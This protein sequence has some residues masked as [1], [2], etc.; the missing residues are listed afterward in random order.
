MAQD[1]PYAKYRQGPQPVTIG[2]PD[3]YRPREEERKDVATQLDEERVRIARENLA[4]EQSGQT[5]QQGNAKFD[6]VATLRKEFNALPQ[7]REY[8]SVMPLLM[9]GLQTAPNPQG[10]NALIYAYAKIMD[11]GSVVRESEGESAANTA[12]FFAAQAEKIKKNLGWS[13]ARGLPAGAAQGLRD[14]MNR[15]VAQM[16]KTYG[17]ER[18]RYQE[19][20]KRQNFDPNDVVGQ[21]PAAPFIDKYLQLVP[22]ANQSRENSAI[23]AFNQGA[24]TLDPKAPFSTDQDKEV[25]AVVNAAFKGG[26]TFE[27][28]DAMH[29]A[30]TKNPAAPDGVPLTEQHRQYVQARDRGLPVSEFP[31]AT[32][33]QPTAMQD[34]ITNAAKNPWG[35]ALFGGV[36]ADLAGIP[37]RLAGLD[38]MDAM[39]AENPKATFAGEMAGNIG[40]TL[41]TGG[42]LKALSGVARL[43]PEVT[44]MLANPLTADALYGGI[45]GGMS[46]DNPTLGAMGGV[47]AALI[48]GSLSNKITG[49]LAKRAAVKNA[50]AAVPSVDDLKSQAKSLYDA[51]DNSGA[52]LDP[53]QTANLASDVRAFLSKEGVIS[54]KGSLSEVHPKV[55]EALR[56]VDEYAGQTMDPAQMQTVRKVAANAAQS[57]DASEARVGK[58]V[59]DIVDSHI[60]PVVPDLARAR[61]ISSRYLQG[62]ELEQARQLAGARAGQFSGSGFENALR[63]EYR[64]LD[65]GIVKGQN[66]FD[67]AVVEAIMNVG[68]GT[69]ASNFA[70]GVGKLAPTGVVSSG[71]SAGVPFGIGTAVGGPA[72]GSALSAGSLTTGAIGRKIATAMTDRNAQIAEILARN[73]G[74]LQLVDIPPSDVSALL[75]GGAS[76]PFAQW[77]QQ[78]QGQ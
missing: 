49:G 8:T 77:L 62:Q 55:K 35:A 69:P 34:I 7:V 68:R 1:N 5:Y 53:A 33:G 52:L 54:P 31:A 28:L 67:P 16:A 9:A 11:P 56:L 29:R 63:T 74:P 73:G 36:N 48:G 21:S 44:A 78:Q 41:A 47:A 18:A 76:I 3:L 59:R 25:A 14:E 58:V 32:S 19:M 40:G 37:G 6:N 42:S 23:G 57:A 10:D 26:A 70:R 24:A 66:M 4:R 15:K 75:A 50:E 45:S 13:D 60:D 20:A 46:S 39:R 17:V 2:A 65:R 22:S 61:D 72:L 71:L 38:K 43:T 30:M 64:G 51:V 27:Q 12:G